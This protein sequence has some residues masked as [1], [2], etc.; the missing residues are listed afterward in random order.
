[1]VESDTRGRSNFVAMLDLTGASPLAA[2]PTASEAR[3]ASEADAR[4]RGASLF[5][6][7]QRFRGTPEEIFPF[8]ADARNLEAITPPWLRFTVLTP[9]PIA[10][11]VGALIDYRLRWRVV[12]IRWR[13]RIAA[14]EPSRRFVDEQIRG[15][16]R[17][18]H[19]EHT[20]ESD[21]AFTLMRDRVH[22]RAPFA[23]IAH[24]LIVR[25]DVERIFAYRRD[26]LERLLGPG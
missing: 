22:Y 15:P 2:P 8:F 14:W 9:R 4:M 18:W 5:E 11:G 20:F 10:M 26:A 13:T 24:P 17:L 7:T 1:M 16:Y 12:P 23:A 19:H 21:G 25:R 6:S 3:A